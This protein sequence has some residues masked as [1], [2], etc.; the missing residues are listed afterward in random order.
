MNVEEKNEK[1]IRYTILSD[2]EIKMFREYAKEYK[3]KD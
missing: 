3:P 2:N 1:E